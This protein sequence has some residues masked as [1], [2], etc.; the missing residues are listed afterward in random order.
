M[1]RRLTGPFGTSSSRSLMQN[2]TTTPNM[3]EAEPTAG[4]TRVL[5]FR[6]IAGNTSTIVSSPTVLLLYAQQKKFS[7]LRSV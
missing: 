6:D 5:W 1:M 7:V 2:G 4:R 3:G